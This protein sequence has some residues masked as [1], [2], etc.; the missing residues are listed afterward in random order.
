MA[1][2]RAGIYL[3][4]TEAEDLGVLPHQCHRVKEVMANPM[5][6]HPQTPIH[7]VLHLMGSYE[8]SVLIIADGA[9]LLGTITDRQIA[10]ADVPR[11]T[12]IGTIT[13]AHSLS[14][15]EDDLVIDA[16]QTMRTHEVS[17]LP[18]TDAN[19][20]ISGILPRTVAEGAGIAH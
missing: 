3:E 10:L 19:G 18:V 12:P 16:L 5:S 1:R 14:C 11:S 17:A 4:T 8:M 13:T 2:R 15:T 6:V 7:E 20:S 9:M